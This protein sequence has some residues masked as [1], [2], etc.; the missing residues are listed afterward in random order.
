MLSETIRQMWIKADFVSLNPCC[1]GICSLRH[2]QDED[3]TPIY[4]CLNPCCSG[5]CSLRGV[6]LLFL[7]QW[8]SLNPCCS[9]ICSLRGCDNVD[10]TGG[11]LVLILVVVEYALWELFWHREQGVYGSLNPCCSGICSLS[12]EIRAKEV[13]RSV[14]ILVVVEYALWVFCCNG[15]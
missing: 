2:Y 11:A 8:W 6:C 7:L 15:E 13:R 12:V 9:G 14:L 1:S 10:E 5:I 4:N 3:K